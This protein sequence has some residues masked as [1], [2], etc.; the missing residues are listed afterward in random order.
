[1]KE[2]A[3][4]RMT[5]KRRNYEVLAKRSALFWNNNK[6][7]GS[8]RGTASIYRNAFYAQICI[9]TQLPCWRAGGQ[10]FK[11]L[12]LF[13]AREHFVWRIVRRVMPLFSLV[14]CL[15]SSLLCNATLPTRPLWHWRWVDGIVPTSQN[16]VVHSPLCVVPFPPHTLPLQLF[17]LFLFPSLIQS[18]YFGSMCSLWWLW[19]V[20]IISDMSSAVFTSAF[21][22][23]K[24]ATV[25]LYS[26]FLSL[27]FSSDVPFISCYSK[28]TSVL[29][30]PLWY[31][32]SKRH[33]SL[34]A[35]PQ[36]VVLPSVLFSILSF[37][38]S[39][40]EAF[41]NRMSL[42]CK[43]SG[44]AYHLVEC[45]CKFVNFQLWTIQKS[46][47]LDTSFFYNL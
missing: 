4:C 46:L 36:Q 45:I 9:L 38:E 2:T 44:L 25:T 43:S 17:N 7:K 11:E 23:T 27:L 35:G 10:I 29:L 15:S 37:G 21:M 33:P 31:S 19:V 41:R 20:E 30:C 5:Q 47:S 24:R 39:K 14:I 22:S 28:I 40:H 26:V 18:L 12:Q 13:D 3:K 1:M 34:F 6:I 8:L 16:H 42:R 32:T